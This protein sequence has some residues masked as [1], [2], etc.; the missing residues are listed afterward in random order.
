MAVRGQMVNE[1]D[2]EAPTILHT[3]NNTKERHSGNSQSYLNTELLCMYGS[4]FHEPAGNGR[5]ASAPGVCS[6][7]C[8]AVH[9]FAL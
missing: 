4:V 5:D 1:H 9:F 3:V 7:S 2:D 8:P 6:Q